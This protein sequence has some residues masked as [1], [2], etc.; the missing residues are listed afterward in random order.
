MGKLSAQEIEFKKFTTLETKKTS[1]T[2]QRGKQIILS[3]ESRT[4][5]ASNPSIVTLGLREGEEQL[6]QII[7]IKYF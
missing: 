4:R 6:L 5:I 7:E 1:Y 2:F 3:E